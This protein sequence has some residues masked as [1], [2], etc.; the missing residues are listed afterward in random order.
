MSFS[1]DYKVLDAGWAE[2]R[3]SDGSTIVEGD[4]SYL[5]DSL[6]E[7]AQMAINLRRGIEYS[8]VVFMDEPP[9][10]QLHVKLVGEE[11][12]YEV[13]HF[14]DWES[15]GFW[16]PSDFHVSLKGSIDRQTVIDEVVDVLRDIHENVGV[17]KYKDLWIEHDFPMNEFDIL[18]GA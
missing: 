9:E 17:E 10:I 18:T 13:R 11:V 14:P 6:K 2:V 7:L 5:H 8:R 4:V 15:W 3:I 12:T 16:D 1:L